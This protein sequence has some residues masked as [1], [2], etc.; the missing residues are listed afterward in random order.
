MYQG[1]DLSNNLIGVLLR[2]RQDQVAYMADVEAMFYQVKVTE[3][4]CDLLRFLW[5][6]NR[7]V[8]ENAQEYQMTVHIFGAT[9][10]PSIANFALQKTA[11]D[12]KFNYDPEVIKTVN[13]NFYVDDCLKSVS[14]TTDAIRQAKELRELM[15]EGGF[16]LT[17]WISNDPEV[18][19]S[20]PKELRAKDVK[21]LDL[22][23]DML[24]IERALGVK[25]CVEID[26]IGF[27]VTIKERPFTRR[28]ITSVVSSVFDPLDTASPFVLPAK[29]LLQDLCR[30][31]VGWDEQIP[32]EYIVI[33]QK[34]LQNLPHLAEYVIPRCYVPKE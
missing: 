1:P 16:K 32:K 12:N 26:N 17:K 19:R 20:I 31:K 29:I 14:T 33:W 18:L 6:P 10:S 2:V 11:E 23:R 7:N 28:G 34:W 15:S 9:S 27:N 30:K 3:N 4:D 25:W 8:K 21:D 24:P 13:N 22:R 5:W